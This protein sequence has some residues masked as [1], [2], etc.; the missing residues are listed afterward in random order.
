MNQTIVELGCYRHTD[1]SADPE[2]AQYG[3]RREVA[4][5]LRQ[6]IDNFGQDARYRLTGD[7]YY[8]VVFSPTGSMQMHRFIQGVPYPVRTAALKVPRNTSFNVQ[9]I[10][11]DIRTTVKVDGATLVDGE[12]QGE[13]RGWSVIGVITHWSRGDST[14]SC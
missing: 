5:S 6:L 10:R 7:D 8:E 14:M 12:I 3:I 13:L 1:F 4:E 11:R 9:V 2:R